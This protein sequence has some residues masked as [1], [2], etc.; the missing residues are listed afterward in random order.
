MSAFGSTLLPMNTIEPAAPTIASPPAT[1]EGYVRPDGRVGVRN[2]LGVFIV[3]NCAATAARKVADW[4]TEKRLAA[5]PHVDGVL[6]FVHELGC[7]MEKTGE[8]MDLLRRTLGGTIRH[9]NLAGAVVLALGCERNNIYAF[10]EQEGL[11]P[12]PLLKSIVLQEVGGTLKAIE[13]GIAAIQ[14]MLPIANRIE[15]QPVAA[16][17]LVVGLQTADTG[18]GCSHARAALGAAVDLLVQHGGTA[19]VSSTNGNAPAL[20]GR[21]TSPQVGEQLEQ[22]IHWWKDYTAGRDTRSSRQA[23]AKVATP[24]AEAAPQAG[25]TALQAVFGYA[26]AVPAT[27]LV[28]M[29]S[30]GYEAVSAT[31]QIASGANLICVLTATG[32][33]F[34]AAGAPTVKLAADSALFERMQDDLD[35]DCGEG[36]TGE[37][38][39][40]ELGQR[41]FQRWLQHASGMKT[42]S[43]ELGL[44]ENEFVPWPIGVFA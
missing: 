19:I 20:V 36:T 7:G 31:G 1:F 43:E 18:Q 15:R 5:Y 8:P 35:I 40:P 37:L 14:E 23:Q 25:S 39:V 13:D 38:A 27:G 29:D 9:P 32:S 11:Q 4:F 28:L 22:R 10:L 41:I 33:G 21:V 44:G 2:Y 16:R 30:P 6:P 12:G 34:G 24:A 3:G 42:Q 17:H 26:H